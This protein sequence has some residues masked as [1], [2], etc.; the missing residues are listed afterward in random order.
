MALVEPI[1]SLDDRRIDIFRSLKGKNLAKDGIFI[2]EGQRVVEALL[3]S[4]LEI[5]CALVTQRWLE[6]LKH[7]FQARPGGLFPVYVIDEKAMQGLVGFGLHQG[8]IVA[9]RMP[10]R[11]TL[12]EAAG[13]WPV[14]HLVVALDRI[15]DSENMGLILRNC[16]AFGVDALIVDKKSSDPYLRR[17]VRVSMGAVFKMPIVYADRLSRGI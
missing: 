7:E 1:L 4:N 8:V 6:R 2:A 17:S 10:Y 12:Q 15:V 3:N 16:L 5:V 9:A 13:A 11:L 14:P